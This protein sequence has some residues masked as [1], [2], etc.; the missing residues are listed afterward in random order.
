MIWRELHSTSFCAR[1]VVTHVTILPPPPPPLP[2]RKRE[3]FITGIFP[4]RN[5]FLLQFKINSKKS[6]PGEITGVTVLNEFQ[7]NRAVT[8]QNSNYFW[9]DGILQIIECSSPE[10]ATFDILLCLFRTWSFTL[11]TNSAA[12]L[13]MTKVSDAASSW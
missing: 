10:S 7:N 6:P 11:F 4:T 9:R 12:S 5:L 1:N 13:P 3:L 8:R 2:T